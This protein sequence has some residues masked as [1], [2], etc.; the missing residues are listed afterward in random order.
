MTIDTLSCAKALEAA[1]LPREA[2]E[3]Q[4]SALAAH[5]LPFLVSRQDLDTMEQRLTL[6]I[7]RAVHQQTVRIFGFVFAIVG[8]LDAVLFALLRVVR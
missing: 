7:E 4:T 3:A 5:V 1:G 2:A 6:V 8:L